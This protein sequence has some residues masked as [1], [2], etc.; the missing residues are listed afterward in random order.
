MARD[1]R[2]QGR[3]NTNA[4]G[5]GA[6]SNRGRSRGSARGRG[7]GHGASV[8]QYLDD[9]FNAEQ[10]R[11]ARASVSNHYGARNAVHYARFV[12]A[13]LQNCPPQKLT[14][15]ITE[16]GAIWDEC[17]QHAAQLPVESLQDLLAALARIPFSSA[18][19]PPM[20]CDVAQAVQALL[21]EARKQTTNA[22]SKAAAAELVE[23]VCVALGA[24]RGE[25]RIDRHAS[26][27]RQSIRDPIF[28]PSQCS[29]AH[30]DAV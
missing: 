3:G 6:N 27:S 8:V 4:R 22:D 9:N 10:A 15:A 20:L 16:S 11:A 21:D 29:R 30:L 5:R 24:P 25:K 2:A 7:S 13:V 17:W 28:S 23:Q 14:S 19:K 26:G 18:L 1:R 12:R